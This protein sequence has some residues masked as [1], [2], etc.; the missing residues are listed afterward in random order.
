MQLPVFSLQRLQ[1]T[2]FKKEI[3]IN[4][5]VDFGQKKNSIA[6]KYKFMEWKKLP[7]KKTEH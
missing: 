5:P 6:K 1:K 3:Y 4:V 2:K 7:P